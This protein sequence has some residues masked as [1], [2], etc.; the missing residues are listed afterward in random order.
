MTLVLGEQR[1]ALLKA[2]KSIRRPVED[3]GHPE[4][5]GLS[6]PGEHSEI[7]VAQVLGERPERQ[8]VVRQGNL[9]LLSHALDRAV[10]VHS[11]AALFVI[12]MD[13]R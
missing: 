3:A 1:G 9:G 11:D 4:C 10:V 12:D 6:L 5:I 13:V 8:P 7:G 2:R